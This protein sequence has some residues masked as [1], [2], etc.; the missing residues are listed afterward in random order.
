MSAWAARPFVVD[1]DLPERVRVS[2]ASAKGVAHYA[3]AILSATE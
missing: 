2:L 3:P 1:R